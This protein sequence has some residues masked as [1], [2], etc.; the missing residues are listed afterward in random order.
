MFS[1]IYL[2]YSQY[3]MLN[4]KLQ[5]LGYS[6]FLHQNNLK[7]NLSLY[8]SSILNKSEVMSSLDTYKKIF[9]QTKGYIDKLLYKSK[10]WCGNIWVMQCHEVHYAYC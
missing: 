7:S 1:N 3:E 4:V 2:D 5:T 8:I 9:F 6:Y 10:Q